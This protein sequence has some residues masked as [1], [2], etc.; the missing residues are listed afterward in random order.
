[1]KTNLDFT[2]EIPHHEDESAVL[3]ISITNYEDG[4][5]MY[6]TNEEKACIVFNRQELEALLHIMNLYQQALRVLEGETP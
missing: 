1:M 6:V 5:R 3:K 4:A 2:R